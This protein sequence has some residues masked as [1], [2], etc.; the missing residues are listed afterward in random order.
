MQEI[1][2]LVCDKIRQIFSADVVGLVL[3]DENTGMTT[4]PHVFDHGKR[5]YPAPEPINHKILQRLKTRKPILLRTWEETRQFLAE[6]GLSNI[7]G[8]TPDNSQLLMPFIVSEK[9]T[10][11]IGI[12]KL[13]KNAF[14]EAD[15][16]IL[17]TLVNS[18]SVALENARLFDETQRLFKA[19]QERVNE[20]QIINSI[21][22]GLAAELDF[23]A[24]VDLVGDKLREVL[25]TSDL[26]IRW[27]DEKDHLLYYLYN[28]EHGKRLAIDPM[29]PTPGGIF[30]QISKTRQPLIGHNTAEIYSYSSVI[31]GTDTPKSNISVP[32][33]SSDKVLGIIT[34]ENYE[35]EYAFGDSEQRLLTT[36][37][38]SLGTALENA[39]LFNETQRLLKET[40]QRAAELAI[41]NSVGQALAK[42]LDV[43]AIIKIVGDQVRDTFK[44]EV[45]MIHFYDPKNEIIS[46]AYA[47]DRGYIKL[48]RIK[49]GKGLTSTVIR[50]RKPL[51]LLSTQ[52][53]EKLETIYIPDAVGGEGITKSYL[54]V[55]IIAGDTVIGVVSVQSY[56]ENAYQP[57][58][59]SLLSTLAS[60]M[61]VAIANARQFRAEQERVAELEIINSIQ[62]G[63]A[64]ELDFQ[65]I[66]DLVGDKLRE[67]F[68]ST[69][70]MISWYD[71]EADLAR[72]LY[73]YVHGQRLFPEPTKLSTPGSLFTSFSRNRQPEVWNNKE[74]REKT[75]TV[76]GTGT[77][78]SGVA[79]P[80]ISSDQIIGGIQLYDMEEENAFGDAEIRLLTTIAASLGTALE[81][82]RL[83]DESQ[84]LLKETEQR[85][86]E[87]AILNSVG[88]AMSRQ[89]D[90][91]TITRLVGDKVREIFASECVFISIYDPQTNILHPSYV[92]DKGYMDV[93]QTD[94]YDSNVFNDPIFKTIILD[95]KSLL[96]GTSKDMLDAGANVWPDA[97]GG[98][99]ATSSFLG[100][101]LIV[102]DQVKGLVSVQSYKE[103]AFDESNLRLLSTLASSMGV[104][105][106]NA[107]LFQETQR[108]LDETQQ[109]NSE[110]AIINSV[111]AA[112]AAELSI[113]GIYDAVGDKIRKIFHS[114]NLEI[115]IFDPRTNLETFPYLYEKGMR[116]QQE[117]LPRIET[118]ISAHVA[119]TRETL[120]INENLVQEAEKYGSY[121]VPGTQD[122]KS[123]AYVPLIVGDQVRGLVCLSDFEREH[124]FSDS[125]VRLLQ[126]LVNS[127]SVALENARL[128]AETQRLL[129][130]TSQRA[131][132]LSIINNVSQ[133]MSKQLEVEAIVR[134]VGDQVRDTLRA[135]VVN[136][137]LYDPTEKMIHV[138]YAYDRKYVE[139][140]DFPYGSGLTSKIID[141]RQPLILGSFEEIAS[142]GAILSPNAPDDQL[143]PQS[144]VGVPIVV[145]DKAFGAI[146]VQ[147]YTPY[148]YDESHVRLLSTLASSMGVALENARLFE[149]TRR[150]LAETE[151]RN[152]ELAIISRI[153]QALAGQLDPQGIFELVGVE[154]QEVFDA[155]VVAIITYNRQE[156]LS[157][158]RYLIEKGQR[159]VI[160]PHPPAGFSGHILRTRQPL[161]I[162]HDVDR[163]AAELGSA[164]LTGEAP[165]SYL[166]VPLIAGGEVTGVITLQNIDREEAFSQNDLRLLS[167]LALSMG[168][169]LENARLYQETQH[170]AVEMA[171]LAEIGSDIAST[172]EMEP[173]LERM[174][175]KT[176]E[177]MQVR[178][179]TL[180][181]MQPDGHTLKPIV[182]QGK[183]AAETLTQNIALGHGMTGSIAQ[184]G[185]AEIINE[186][187]HDPRAV[188]IDGT[189]PE[190]EEPECLMIAPMISRGKVIGVM[191][192]YRDRDQGLFTQ[193][194]LDFLVSLARQAAIAIESARLYAET[195]RRATEMAA[196]AEVSRE[197]SATLELQV[198]LERIAGQARELLSAGNSA[199]YLLQA[200][201]ET[202]KAIAA[203]GNIAQEVLA[204]EVNLGSGIIGSIVK[205]GVAEWIDDTAKDP[206]A[207]QI[208]GTS[209]I[210]EGEKLLV[211]PLLIQD[212]AIG[213]L[214]VWRN[215]DDPLFNQ[216]ELSFAISLA[217]Q[218]VVAIENARL[219]EAAQESQRRMADIINFLP[220]PTF[221]ID[222]EGKV[223]AWNYAIEEM[224][225][226]KATEIIG[227]G[228]YE[229]AIPFYGER[230]P[231]LIDTVLLPSQEIE[232]NYTHL[233]RNGDILIGEAISI[234]KG[235]PTYL[236]A[237]ASA[238]KNTK[239]E[240]VGAIESIRNVT[241]QK[242]AEE[243]LKQAKVEAEAANQAK[244]AFLAMM[245]HEIRTPM[246]AIIGMSGLL[247][248]TTLNPDQREFAETIRSSGDS[249]LTIINDILDFSKI[250]AGKMILEEAPFDLRECIEASFDL[251]K[252]NASEKGLELAYQVDEGVPPAVMGDVTRLRQVLINLL[253]N[254][255]KFTE[256]GEVV[257]TVSVGEKKDSLHF[258]V[259]DTGIG[260]QTD[261]ISQ[262]FRPFTQADAS[263]SRR[264]G[265]TGLGLALSSRIVELM[266][267]QMWVESEGVPGKGSTFHFIILAKPAVAWKG[268]PQL[269]GEHPQLRGRRVLLVDDNATNLRIL[270]LQTNIWGMLPFGCSSPSETIDILKKGEAFDLAI[271]DLHMPD[272]T[273][274]E[275][276]EEI[277]RLEASRPGTERMPLVLSTSLGGRE[278][279]RESNEFA[280]VLLKPIR[281]SALYDM[282]IFLFAGK[283]VSA[284]KPT[285]ERP[286]LDPEMA[287]RHPLRILLAE[288][289]VVNQKLALRL[290]SQMGYRADM[291]AN[292]LEVLQA[293]KRQPYDVI[294]MDVQMPEMD[295]LE[296]TR[297]LCAELPIEK[298][299]HIIAMT[300]NAMQ[301]DREMCLETGMDDYLSKPI[302]V[303]ELVNALMRAQPRSAA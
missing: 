33:I 219:F 266:G 65:A 165:K 23:Q 226:V 223:I 202:I 162:S 222:R 19:E 131:S 45:T 67:V 246:N 220:D 102:G 157:Y 25:H 204:D 291:A 24:I 175:S 268:R 140:E 139:T 34:I 182:S 238:L 42:Q 112:L 200:D 16:R 256:Q 22:Q 180:Y 191:T 86:A 69:D 128:F 73:V 262:L 53:D 138:P 209:D 98:E 142:G 4:V 3:H 243:E 267:G 31:S 126:T 227:K 208:Q 287:S 11:E 170:H 156:N 214:A 281:Q 38:A 77:S 99:G 91:K 294:F 79:I 290:L 2:D 173:V 137:Y 150:L 215:P 240:A 284:A 154:L 168:V 76:P 61:G 228:D 258:A 57:S 100:V 224:T 302:Q 213:A 261:R 184:R 296:A 56:Q 111:Q 299:P 275:L 13:A 35:R 251:I 141:T 155:Q 113:Q 231:I 152:R 241:E 235:Q 55:P 187:E 121:L 110:L 298:R 171:A 169:A 158:W 160:A 192:V 257:L 40:E 109:R 124:A 101:P 153:G 75:P 29:A 166:G 183:Y 44:S 97:E 252:V 259:R 62:K 194:E 147:S 233:Q 189:P 297:R 122:A 72:H 48:S 221:V 114:D 74:Q 108:L 5:Y 71:E 149:E 247:M 17:Q 146:D 49:Y 10:G 54:G 248:D 199:V 203:E 196:L 273:G 201:G 172:H 90:I 242:R 185:I 68:K 120:V 37:A 193:L 159:Q 301:G 51:V 188:H 135:E 207:I 216:A 43:D 277:R 46:A 50:T 60:S 255:V 85:A 285:T 94:I 225:G 245:S 63:L 18:M 9:V 212:H 118:G 92:F 59:V 151:Q 179:I 161:L 81:N 129:E 282:L 239:G 264:Y 236:N 106:E 274:V 144:F 84:R 176:R 198:V 289:N 270:E 14:S 234:L 115:R 254:S 174:A 82:A 123:C 117:A 300:A 244:S 28:Y 12:G 1:Y 116:V 279:A 70:M 66:V 30:E 64:A 276:A 104:A 105:I 278:E 217:Q 293:V 250:E 195:E 210:L 237:T 93:E 295:G 178:D 206:R 127:M 80:I 230:R 8:P 283:E 260:I 36:I 103:Y 148:K 78:V 107:R 88:D 58:H 167:T 130:E 143:M 164:V 181:L 96:F 125:D 136:I 47:Y 41:L 269:E 132:E 119:R 271:L 263:T 20:V 190:D 6:Y 27:Y 303:E 205:S 288:D 280:A 272:M 26:G 39:R 83:F 232:A 95:R 211:A 292:G 21:Q 134:T 145:G 186:P 32:V 177:L 7:G 133:A 52:D 163:R 197:I 286:T 89:L 253:G 265:G 229:Y 249:L 15:V 87:L 218:A